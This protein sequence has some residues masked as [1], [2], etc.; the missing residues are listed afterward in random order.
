M[1]L[2]EGVELQLHALPETYDVL[3][4]LTR[5]H[6][7]E[8]YGTDAGEPSPNGVIATVRHEYTNYNEILDMIEG[9]VGKGDASEQLRWEIDDRIRLRLIEKYP[10][11]IPD[12]A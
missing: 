3:K 4:R 10:G 8:R 1:R 5:L 7:V 9:K 11:Q 2:L 12:E 6:Q